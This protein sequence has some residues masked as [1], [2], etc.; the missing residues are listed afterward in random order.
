LW[1]EFF[2]VPTKTSVDLLW[3]EVA[4][5]RHWIGGKGGEILLGP[6][7]YFQRKTRNFLVIGIEEKIFL[8]RT[9]ESFLA[10]RAT[11]NCLIT[12]LGLIKKYHQSIIK[13][14][15]KYHQS[16]IKVS[17]KYYQSIIKVSSKYRNI[18]GMSN[19]W[20]CQLRE[21]YTLRRTSLVSLNH[22]PTLVSSLN[23][24]IIFLF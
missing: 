10:K 23:S 8:Y 5:G 22:I 18:R 17:S 11:K 6:K 19:T 1:W 24:T 12:L 14:S 15:S 2:L 7:K 4:P 21:N 16:L 3:E 9:S 20:Y 13:V